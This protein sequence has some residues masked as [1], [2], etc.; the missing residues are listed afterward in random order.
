MGT[1]PS[2]EDQITLT[3]EGKDAAALLSAKKRNAPNGTE[4]S[5]NVS[6]Q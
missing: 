4:G 5:S 1:G 6:K 2:K 3:T